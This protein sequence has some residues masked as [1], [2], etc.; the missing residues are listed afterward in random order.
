ML[1]REIIAVCSEI[2]TKH[3]H[4]LYGQNVLF[5]YALAELR[6]ATVSLVLSVRIEQ[7]GSHCTDFHIIGYLSIL[8]KSVD[9]IQ[10]SL[11]SHK[12]NGYFT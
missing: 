3:I 6:K 1:Y 8:R 4:K 9:V 12:N 5:L 2:H 11:K 10:V 7:L